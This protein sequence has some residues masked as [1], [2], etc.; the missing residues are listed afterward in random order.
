MDKMYYKNLPLVG[1]GAH[2]KVYN[3]GNN[4]CIKICKKAKNIQK[5]YQVLIHAEGYPQFPVVYE[6]NGNYMI[7]E[8]I[9]GEKIIDYIAK[10]GLSNDLAKQLTELLKIF[11]KLKFTRLDIKMNEVFITKNNKLKIIDTTRYLDKKASYPFKMLK[12][13]EELGYK[14]QYMNY[15]KGNYPEFY[16]IWNKK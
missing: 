16:K 1:K 6:C 12:T 5:E 7:R 10:N 2:G 14:R 15:L 8:Y 4:R 13:L 3:L 9:N 11:I